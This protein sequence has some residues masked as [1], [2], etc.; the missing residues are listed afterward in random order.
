MIKMK[1]KLAI[2]L[3]IVAAM[4]ITTCAAQESCFAP[5]CSLCPT[6][7]LNYRNSTGQIIYYNVRDYKYSEFPIDGPGVPTGI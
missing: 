1:L 5:S 6:I 7:E 2:T 4:L 3:F